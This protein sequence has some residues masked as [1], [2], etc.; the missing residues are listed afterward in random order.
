[1][2][3]VAPKTGE[4]RKAYL[5]RAYGIGKG[6]GRGRI[7]AEGHERIREAQAKGHSFPDLDNVSAPKAPKA[8]KAATVTKPKAPAE[9]KAVDPAAIRAWAQK[10]GIPVSSRGRISGE[11]ARQYLDAVP[12]HER[13]GRGPANGEKDLRPNPPRLYPEGT[14]WRVDFTYKGEPVT[15]Y[16]SE[17]TACGNCRNSLGWC[18]CSAP[19]VST[20][21]GDTNVRP[22]VTM[23]LPKGHDAP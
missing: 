10:K 4:T 6:S 7:S 1:M 8:P 15:Q 22:R 2:A 11:V 17:R 21:Y 5:H 14:T 23:I 9:A 12:V 20:G 19:Y 13:E 18:G 3:F 16:V